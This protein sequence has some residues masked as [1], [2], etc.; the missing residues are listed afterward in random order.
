MVV[1]TSMTNF[2]EREA[3]RNTWGAV[4]RDTNSNITVLF[5]IG[6]G[7]SEDT[8]KQ[9]FNESNIYK[10][11]IQESFTDSYRNL[12]IK[13]QALLKW[14]STFCLTA[15]YALKTDDDMYVN[16]PNLLSALKKQTLD[17]FIL[18]HVFVDV[19]PVQEKTSKWYTPVKD[20]SEKIYPSFTS[21]TTYSMSVKAVPELYNAS[22]KTKNFWLEDVFITGLCA[23]RAKIPRIHDRGFYYTKPATTGCA[24]RNI[25]TGHGNTIQEIYKIHKELLELKLKCSP[26]LFWLCCVF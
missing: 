9:V 2:G 23:R 3:I 7:G 6:S 10:D 14:I 13:S 21:G 5:L 1:C 24:Y 12:S 18:G 19:H 15:K 17:K 22:L 25:I 8:Q 16:V 26:W 20:F 11:I 4:E